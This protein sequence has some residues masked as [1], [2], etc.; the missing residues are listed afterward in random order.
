M[1]FVVRIPLTPTPE[2]AASLKALQAAFAEAC[3]ALA[4]LVQQSRTWNRVALHHM[5]YRQMRARFP[6]LG[7]QMVCNAIYSV[8]RAARGVFQ[9]PAS[10]YRLQRLGD[11]PLPLLKFGA[12]SPVF[13]DRHTMSIKDGQLSMF[14]LDGRGRFDIGLKL[15]VEHH[16]RFDKLR[17]IVLA[18]RSAGYEL[19]FRFDD[20]RDD[21]AAPPAES[22]LPE[23]VLVLEAPPPAARA[24]ALA[25]VAE[26][27]QDKPQDK[28]PLQ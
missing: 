5:A 16:F 8:S 27:A 19:M 12:E 13:F 25:T 26:R 23:Y 9:S 17:E 14:T 22:D 7:S 24:D 20:V 3:N 6:A 15:E 4:P 1:N 21:A 2:Q 28:A 10:P 11:A 18:R